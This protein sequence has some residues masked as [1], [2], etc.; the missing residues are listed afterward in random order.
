[1]ALAKPGPERTP[2]A[3][4]KARGSRLWKQREREEREDASRK[5]RL[6]H[7]GDGDDQG[8]EHETS[9][10]ESP[11][12]VPNGAGEFWRVVGQKLIDDGQLDC[13]RDMTAFSMMARALADYEAALKII[14]A[15]GFY[16]TSEAGAKYQHPAV[17]V[18]NKSREAYIRLAKQ[19]GLVG[20]LSRDDT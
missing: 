11:A 19:F 14:D 1:M 2:S 18:A 12:W 9:D 17:G 16:C 4:L 20:P 13:D 3:V 8:A 15:E 10:V 5:S 7:S 6:S